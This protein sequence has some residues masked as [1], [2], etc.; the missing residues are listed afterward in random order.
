MSQSKLGKVKKIYKRR[1]ERLTVNQQYVKGGGSQANRV[2]WLLPSSQDFPP[3]KKGGTNGRKNGRDA[4][5]K[6]RKKKKGKGR[7]EEKEEKSHKCENMEE[8]KSKVA[9]VTNHGNVI[10]IRET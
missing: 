5:K 10:N 9:M 1:V 4:M 7:K 3:K 8:V 6:G 2:N